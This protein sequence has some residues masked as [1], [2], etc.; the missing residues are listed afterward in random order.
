MDTPYYTFCDHNILI[1]WSTYHQRTCNQNIFPEAITYYDSAIN[2]IHSHESQVTVRAIHICNIMYFFHKSI[3]SIITLAYFWILI[4]PCNLKDR[5]FKWVD[6]THAIHVINIRCFIN[7][8][9]GEGFTILHLLNYV[10]ELFILLCWIFTSGVLEFSFKSSS[11][12]L[13][14]PYFDCIWVSQ[15][16]IMHVTVIKIWRKKLIQISNTKNIPIRYVLLHYTT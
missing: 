1:Y 11:I 3:A 16:V 7:L 9:F 12:T 10:W 8:H 6:Q 15:P 14:I 13:F 2:C 5:K 4:F